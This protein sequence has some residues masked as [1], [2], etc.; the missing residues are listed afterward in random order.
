MFV[1]PQ[2]ENTLAGS[3]DGTS[4]CTKL[5]DSIQVKTKRVSFAKTLAR[6]SELEQRAYSDVFD[7]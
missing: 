6:I 2:T 1:G 7:T 5:V 3:S 4:M